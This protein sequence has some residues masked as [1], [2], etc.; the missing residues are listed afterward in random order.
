MQIFLE[1][2]IKKRK[3]WFHKNV[4]M[5]FQS[6]QLVKCQF[7]RC[8][9]PRSIWFKRR[10]LHTG[11]YSFHSFWFDPL[12][13]L[14]KNC[15]IVISLPLHWVPKKMHLTS[16]IGTHLSCH[17]HNFWAHH[18]V[19]VLLSTT[20]LQK[21]WVISCQIKNS[22]NKLLS[23]SILHCLQSYPNS[24]GLQLKETGLFSRLRVSESEK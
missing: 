3:D 14:I 10:E 18:G 13:I 9:E 20:L 23:I 16:I 22:E 15:P 17:N 8:A 5:K 2:Q 21:D 24:I 7:S 12:S 19:K 1:D 11:Q 6:S 4:K